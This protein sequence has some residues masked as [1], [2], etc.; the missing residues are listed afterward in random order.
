MKANLFFAIVCS[1][2]VI[3]CSKNNMPVL[4]LET[5][6]LEVPCGGGVYTFNI[7]CNTPTKVSISYDDE[8]SDW[9]F[10]I[11]SFLRQDGI[12]E[13]RIDEYDYVLKDRSA[14]LTITS[15][16][17]SKTL[18]V[19]QLAKPGV[20][21]AQKSIIA[22]DEGGEYRITVAS[23]G[24][25]TVAIDGDGLSWIS[26]EEMN[27]HQGE[28]E[29]IVNISPVSAPDEMRDAVITVRVG[30]QMSSLPVM[31]G[32]ARKIGNILWA[33]CDVGDPNTFTAAPNIRGKLYQ[34]DSKIAYESIFDDMTCPPGF[35]TQPYDGGNTLWQEANNPCPPGWRVPTFEEAQALLG[36][37]DDRRAQWSTWGGVPGAFAGNKDAVTA[38]EQDP[39]GCIFIP[40][41]C[42]RS[43]ATGFAD[44]SHS[45]F[46]QTITRPGHNWGRRCPY[47]H[48]N[49]DILYEYNAENPDAIA[50]RCVASLPE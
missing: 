25:G 50:V 26:M 15:G 35:S 12:I 21:F 42:R 24:E 20:Y 29:V 7:E 2:A 22:L 33:K 48:E 49:N 14:T 47:V 16:E 6:L 30:D 28:N 31:Q 38:T 18:K 23:S 17:V 19:V 37:M 8:Y 46:V 45:A 41:N 44:W 32:Y 10:M 43:Y 1:M 36:T 9:I 13:L 40:E 11:P 4:E 39:K 5:D 27:V 34:Y 3:A